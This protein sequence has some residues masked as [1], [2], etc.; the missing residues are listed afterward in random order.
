MNLPRKRPLGWIV[1][2]GLVLWVIWPAPAVADQE[3]DIVCPCRVEA[4]NMTSV[5]ITFG[6]RN[7][8]TDSDTGPLLAEM[9]FKEI[10]SDFKYWTISG[11]EV[12]LPTVPA[13][14]TRSVQ[15]YTVASRTPRREGSYVLRLSLYPASRSRTIE[16]VTWLSAP[17]EIGTGGK[18]YSSV[19]F[20]GDPKIA[21]D[22]TNARVT[23]PALKNPASGEPAN[24]LKLTLVAH[25][26]LT[27]SG[28]GTEVGEHGLGVD[29]AP[30]GQAN[31]RTVNVPYQESPD[32]EYVSVQIE[33]G[34]GRLLLRQVVAVPEGEEVP[35]RDFSTGNSDMLVDSDEDGVGD[36]NER[37]METDPED[38]SSTPSDSTVDV[39]AMYSQGVPDLYGGDPTTRIRHLFTLA[40]A[41]YEDSKTGVKLRLVG[42][43]QVDIDESSEYGRVDLDVSEE[44]AKQHG[45]DVL[46]LIQPSVS[47][48]GIC[49]SAPLGGYAANGHVS[50]FYVPVAR[51]FANCGAGVLA[52]EI[53]HVMGLG[54]SYVQRH[55]GTYRWARGHGVARSFVT[56]MAYSQEYGNAPDLDVFSDP[57]GD[58]KG[59]PC[60]VA[61][62]RTDGANAVAAL[63]VTRFQIAQIGEA[64]PD[65]DGDGFVDPVDA[66]P[67]DPDEHL[68]HDGDGIGNRKDEDD[69]GDGV[70]DTLDLFPLDPA[71]WEDTDADGVGDNTDA[72]P[73]DPAEWLDTDADGVGDNG[74]RFPNDPAET[75]DTDHDGV[76]NNSD[77]FPFDTREWLDTDGDGIG[78]NADDDTDNDGVANVH[79]VYPQ[80]AARSDASS[81]RIQLDHGA[82]ERLSLSPAGDVDNDNRADFLIGTVN[83]D[84]EERQ[85]TSA[86]Y[87]IA[88]AD[89]KAAD[90]ADGAA[91]RVVNVE[92]IVGQPGSWKF[93]GERDRDNVGYSV[94]TVGDIS[95]DGLPEFLIGAPHENEPNGASRRGAAY[96]V[97]P[98]ALT[99]ADVADGTAD[100]V[101]ELSNVPAQANSWKFVGEGGNK[102]SGM[103]VGSLG[104]VNADGVPDLVI[105]A[106]GYRWTEDPD[107]GQVYL[108]SGQ[109]LKAADMAD[110]DEDGVIELAEIASQTGSWKLAGEIALDQV[111]AAAPSTYVDE[112]G[113]RRLIVHAP[114]FWNEGRETGVVYL[115]ALSELS[116][117]DSADGEAD[118]VVS[119]DRAVAEPGSWQLVGDDNRV[120]YGASIGDHDGD[121]TVDVIVRTSYD[122][123]FLSGAD[124]VVADESDGVRDRVIV[125]TGQMEAPNSW[126]SG[127]SYQSANNGGIATGRI[128]GDERDDLIVHNRT[129][130]PRDTPVFLLSGAAL[131]A[132]EGRGRVRYDE[133]LAGDGS[134]ELRS[135]VETV[136]AV[137]IAGDVDLD[138]KE[139]MLLG[140]ENWV[141]LVN[142]ADL[143][144]LDSADNSRNKIIDL[145]QTTGDTDQD[146]IDDVTDP[147][148]DNDGFADFEDK[149]PQD[150]RE[151]AD[152]DGDRVG[153][154]TDAFPNDWNRRFDTD[155]DGI[156]DRDDTDDDGDGI[157]DAED[158]YPLDTDN[159]A[160]DNVDDAD[161]D[162]DG[163]EDSQDAFPLDS[164][165][166]ADFD[167]DGIGDNA[168]TDDDN[169]GVPDTSD[170]L[171]FDAGESSDRDGDSVGDN[172]DAFPDDPDE[173]LDSD[174]DGQGN[175]AD[176]DDDNDG[177]PDSSDAFPFDDA[178]S[179][180]SDSDGVGNNNDAFPNDSSEWADSDGDGIGDNAD[181]D[182]DNDGY[183]DGADLYPFD[184][185][186]DRLFIFRLLGEFERAWTGRAVSGAGDVDSDGAA[187]VLIG[188]PGVPDPEVGRGHTPDT[189]G[190]TYVVS[191]EDLEPS[192]TSDGARDGRIEIG[193]VATQPNS[194]A[195]R[196]QRADDHLGF[197]L[198]AAGDIGG[199]GKPDWLFGASG[200]N[201]STAAAYLVS[202]AD[203]LR[204]QPVGSQEEVTSITDVLRSSGTW[205]LTGEGSGDD[206]LSTA[207]V[208]V[209]GDTDGDGKP[210]LLIGTPSY[211]ESD[212][213]MGPGAAYLVSSAHL[214]SANAASTGGG[215]RIDLADL[216]SGSGVWR[217]LGENNDDRAGASV[218]AAGDIDGDGLADFMIGAYGHATAR[219][220]DGA[221]YL[222]AAADLQSA[223]EADGETDRSIELEN[224]HLQ[225]NSW[226][227]V[228]ESW[229]NLAGHVLTRGDTNG[230]DE[231]EL[232]ISAAGVR[233]GTGAVYILPISQLSNADA[234]DGE[235]DREINL[236]NVAAQNNSWK[237]LGEGADDNYSSY[238][239][240]PWSTSVVASDVDADGISDLL[241][242]APRH[243]GHV[244]PWCDPEE[245]GA[246]YVV[247]GAD[248]PAADSADGDADGE[249]R[250]GN[251][252]AQSR[253]W[254]L[255]GSGTERLGSSVAAAGDLDGDGVIDLVIG[256]A[257]QLSIDSDCRRGHGEGIAT[258]V[259]GAEL[260]IADRQDGVQDGVIDISAVHRWYQRVDFDLDGIEDALDLDDDD[261][262]YADTADA[263][264]KNPREWADSDYDGIGDNE[265]TDDDND[266]AVDTID[267]FPFNPHET[268]DSDGDGVGDN[269]DSD[270]DND[271]VA[272]A[273]DA[274]PLDP[275][276]WSDEDGDGIGDN[277][278][279]SIDTPNADTDGDG[280]NNGRD[281]D[282][283]N[284]GVLDTD[285]LFPLNANKS[286]LFFYRLVGETRSFAGSDFDG[287]GRNDLIVKSSSAQNSVYLVSASEI[288]DVDDDDGESDHVVDFDRASSLRN[289]W[290]LLR[291]RGTHYL[292]PAGD[293]D[294]DDKDDL[295]AAG[296]QDTFVVPASSLQ[297]A[298]SADDDTDRS[299]TVDRSLAS[300][301]VGAWRLTA[302]DLERGVY[303]LAD[304]NADGHT[305][306]LIGAPMSAGSFIPSDGPLSG[307]PTD[308]NIPTSGSSTGYV[309]SGADWA[310]AD[311]LD[312][313][314]DRVV[315]LDQWIARPGTYKLTTRTGSD[316]GMSVAGAGDFDGDGYEDLMVSVP[317]DSAGDEIRAEAVYLLSGTKLDSFDAADGSTDGT[318]ELNRTLGEGFWQLTGENLDPERVLATAGDVDGDG[319]SDMLIASDNGV[320]LIAGG[321]LPS[322]DAAD[323]TSDRIVRI[324]NAVAQTGSYRFSAGVTLSPE[325]RVWGVGDVDRDSM[326]DILITRNGA[327]TAHLVTAR[328]FGSLDATDGIVNATGIS[329]LPNSWV[330]KIQGADARFDGTASAGDLDGDDRPE[331]IVGIRDA[332]D[333]TDRS[334][335]V[336]SAVELA[337]A[338]SLDDT[339]D[340][341]IALDSVARRWTGD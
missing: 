277:V 151:W 282:D 121:G 153:D 70:A 3:I 306:L 135:F 115:I 69:D 129:T 189:H 85:W 169:D 294:F 223:D 204:E 63:K 64:K 73:N 268:A 51:V 68:D 226:K 62:D 111:G 10:D 54:H 157:A 190:T 272:D 247:S 180:D 288:A 332:T 257:G 315:D 67:N 214:T 7:L 318:I 33:D 254:K 295:V 133:Y 139:D 304:T 195:I 259:S 118:G 137:A 220:N 9:H 313:S 334:A 266:G 37:L 235:S 138:G 188:A 164:S 319:L 24:G 302:T 102:Q 199:D 94:A 206:V 181:T 174:G 159:D 143:D 71:D 101:V 65:S 179:V 175:N 126:N 170:A 283:D 252:A 88:A 330:L 116:A 340:R 149:F 246:V 200:R 281:T 74:D 76:G 312:G 145:G 2:A 317:G 152:S 275:S 329:R 144:A 11:T 35:T 99:A 172:S 310:S 112:N 163:V 125:L 177:T 320:Y 19:Y 184:A 171:P 130:F 105:G 34:D 219:N 303:S 155:A 5:D 20:D 30:G 285:D 284:D 162:G 327:S 158:D 108:I 335:Y 75:V 49:G 166:S 271:G 238:R 287:D 293:V 211:S 308:T 52:H 298:D 55:G 185:S 66:L 140:S 240:F 305:E 203:L 218:S 208:A 205:E 59:S 21:I 58:C 311:N 176:P 17:I 92:E 38:A 15:T 307:A 43:Q 316:S 28:G 18:A 160:I 242:G 322:A 215:S 229:E 269:A 16:S 251:V 134:W 147:D 168:D 337:V 276:E 25:S 46:V 107:A 239:G 297:A 48:S 183:T 182:D 90:A 165:E 39:L 232:I 267:P 50:F 234:A 32:L 191:G 95:G 265:D 321:D 178:E 41:I 323:N 339:Q 209:A 72:F 122:A 296:S 202:S 201:N 87:L 124:F 40:S 97:S 333:T 104:D 231:E 141:Y 244:S 47:G 225:P 263:F 253:S 192:D 256:S 289:S 264:P 150:A 196:G 77:A 167:G 260:A 292:S 131:T 233:D 27:L 26:G 1:V 173:T 14:S 248:L 326:D 61:T 187:E 338:D 113:V 103:S 279:T 274:F 128:D 60:G 29:L 227:L 245:H 290:K 301:T 93:V 230:D 12:H 57:E 156:A 86:A 314:T 42:M 341:S 119:L 255:T 258:I 262:G 291:V 250:L 8:R 146:G 13:S 22:G 186:R 236:S 53:G 336:F 106:P 198:S 224:V 142:A 241:I 82:N 213:A 324:T 273:D 154:N 36:V 222:V 23:L 120:R 45:A 207:A 4:S 127:S 44:L 228:G 56:V 286:D 270:D 210:E 261:D 109:S 132:Y 91:D 89:L 325:L 328:D 193:K 194:W 217:F 243:K 331:L 280:I 81:Y 278:D 117:A 309:A 100:G 221:V 136:E 84:S 31:A 79:D 98:A 212:S 6:V 197:S 161:D 80:D 78:D 237:L 110:G 249:I 148:D 123:Y 299:I 96:L 216:R 114:G 83:Y 300:S